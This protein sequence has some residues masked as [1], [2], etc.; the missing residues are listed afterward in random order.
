MQTEHVMLEVRGTKVEVA[1]EVLLKIPFFAALLFKNIPSKRSAQGH[2]IVDIDP[3]LLHA[4][5][6]F[7][8]KRSPAF[9]MSLS[10]QR[11]CRLVA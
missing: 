3:V 7:R 2:T 6:R 1:R 10:R 5:L 8:E 9:L 4:V 11:K